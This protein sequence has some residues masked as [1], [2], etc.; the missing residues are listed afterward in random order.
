MRSGA[1][2]ACGHCDSIQHTHTARHR[3]KTWPD[4]DLA[5]VIRADSYQTLIADGHCVS[6]RTKWR[7]VATDMQR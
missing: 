6:P 1:G 3:E 7:F 5:F 2:F 4:R